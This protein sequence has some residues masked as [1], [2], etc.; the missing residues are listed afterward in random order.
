MK[1]LQIADG[2]ADLPAGYA[3]IG[4]IGPDSKHHR[5]ALRQWTALVSP[6]VQARFAVSLRDRAAHPWWDHAG[7]AVEPDVDFLDCLGQRS[8]AAVVIMHLFDAWLRH[9]VVRY[10]HATF[11]GRADSDAI[12]SPGWLLAMLAAEAARQAPLSSACNGFKPFVYAG[13]FQWYNW[14]EEKHRPWGWGSGP[15]HARRRASFENPRHCLRDASTPR[16]SGP[17][18]FA[19]GPLLLLSVPLVRWYAASAEAAAELAAALDSRINRTR[20]TAA[21]AGGLDRDASSTSSGTFTRLLSL[22]AARARG[23][24]LSLAEAGDLD[25]RLFDDILLGRRL[26][27]GGGGVGGAPNVTILSFPH[28]VFHDFPCGAAGRIDGCRNGLRRPFNWSAQGTPLLA[29]RVRQPE[30]VSLVL[31]QMRKAQ[32]VV[33]H[34]AKCAPLRLDTLHLAAFRTPWAR[35]W[36]WCTTPFVEQKRP[37]ASQ[38]KKSKAKGGS[39]DPMMGGGRRGRS[40]S[41]MRRNDRNASTRAR[42][43]PV[44][45]IPIAVQ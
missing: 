38:R 13:S 28:G 7:D 17:F 24:F 10:P 6:V 21:D 3:V 18:P 32:F 44:P 25:V 31:E 40:I 30:F 14:D 15:W 9:A 4:I 20:D 22:E 43:V 45:P 5:S 1:S 33:P 36:Q 27:L 8:G 26:A 29:H 2:Q 19:A 23:Q 12:P 11:I 16:C 37:S 34:T 41:I 39:G 35:S 42:A